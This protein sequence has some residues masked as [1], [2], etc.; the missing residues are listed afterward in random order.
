ML[1]ALASPGVRTIVAGT[2]AIAAAGGV[3]EVTCPVVG[4]DAGSPALGALLVAA[5]CAGS[6]LG[7]ALYGSRHGVRATR[8]YLAFSA[9]LAV[10]FAAI[11]LAAGS[12][13]VLA[14]VLFLAGMALAPMLASGYALIEKLAPAGMVTEAFAWTST[15][16]G[17]GC[18]LGAAGAG[19][20]IELHGTGGAFVFGA[21]IAALG[22]AVTATRRST[23]GAP[24]IAP[25]ATPQPQE[26]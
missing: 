24:D 1:G 12:V 8:D 17:T 25:I 19:A 26:A 13:V 3:V 20:L 14:P 23:L 10:G 6:P 18:A 21:A 15:A 5:L 11:A 2:F 7:G 22:A 4:I 16:F 9:L